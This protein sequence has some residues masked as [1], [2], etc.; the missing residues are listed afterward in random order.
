MESVVIFQLLCD[1][2][3]RC[4]ATKKIDYSGD[5]YEE[6]IAATVEHAI[7]SGLING[8]EHLLGIVPTLIIRIY[9][10]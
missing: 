5:E 3:G 1:S 7:V 9:G 2:C 4:R 10:D 6:E 8:Y